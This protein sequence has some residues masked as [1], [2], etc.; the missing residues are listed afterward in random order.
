MG[1]GVHDT[2][3]YRL[4]EILMKLNQGESLYPESLASEFG[5]TIRTIQRDINVRL[6]YLPLEKKDGHY[7]MEQ[8]FLGKFG[9]ADIRH[10]SE[11]AGVRGLFPSLS[12]EVLRDLF[13]NRMVATFLVKGHN[14]ED[15]SGKKALFESLKTA[16]SKSVLIDFDYNKEEAR[17]QYDSVE[18][19]KLL[20][21]KGIWY[22]AGM[23]GGKIKTFSVS[24]MQSVCLQ[25]KQ[26]SKKP[27]IENQLLSEDGI[28]FS[29]DPQEVV[30]A[31]AAEVAHFFKRRKLIANQVIEKEA[32][33][34][35]LIIS[36][37]IGHQN[38]VLP[39]VRYWIPHL[40]IVTPGSLQNTMDQ[41]L[42]SY[43]LHA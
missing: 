3:V 37:T 20:N 16:T 28:W 22:L 18:P 2:L 7:A 25:N 35:S 31:V 5:V 40:R 11:L 10:F 23:D 24:R 26:F 41:E 42:K 32:Q 29:D 19:Y 12:E 6:A 13:D 14:Y 8:S 39:I 4:A 21:Q 34:G 36:A 30:I 43:L 17:K 15:L 27:H 9:S 38:Q 33:D 1:K